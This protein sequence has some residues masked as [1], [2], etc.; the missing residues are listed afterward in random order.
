MYKFRVVLRFHSPLRATRPLEENLVEQHVKSIAGRMQTVAKALLN[1]GDEKALEEL[2]NNWKKSTTIVFPRKQYNGTE[3]LAIHAAQIV[4]VIHERAKAL[5]KSAAVP[6][7]V[8]RQAIWVK[9]TL[10]GLQRARAPITLPDRI[11]EVALSTPRRSAIRVF[12]TVDPP[13]NTEV[14]TIVIENKTLAELLPTLLDH[15]RLG[16]MRKH[17]FGQ[18]TA[19][20]VELPTIGE[21]GGKRK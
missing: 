3:Q 4:G 7:E 20:F 17:G 13:A 6:Y 18:F 8:V 9:P 14:F 19:H 12:E 21:R 5:G 15:G 1:V 2:I 10:I 11:E 16:A